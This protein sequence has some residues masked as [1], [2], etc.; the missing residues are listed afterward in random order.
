MI[1]TYL[2]S[3]AYL[4]SILII[5]TII[6]SILNYFLKLPVNIIKI[7]I[8][9]ISMLLS[10]YFLGKNIKEKAYLEGIKYSV[11]YLLFITI[12]KIILKTSFN[13]KVVIIYFLLLFTGALGATIGINNQKKSE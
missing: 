8:P 7:I 12:I 10:S 11:I 9:I 4:F 5:L 6:L 3:Y 2:K 13:Y 1:K